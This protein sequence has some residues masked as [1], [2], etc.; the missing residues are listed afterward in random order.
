M[1]SKRVVFNIKGN[2]YR[3]IVYI[4]RKLPTLLIEKYPPK[5][6]FNDLRFF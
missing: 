5:K 4:N 2:D 1:T 3:L 6:F